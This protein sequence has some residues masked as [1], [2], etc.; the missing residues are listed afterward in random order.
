MSVPGRARL[1]GLARRWCAILRGWFQVSWAAFGVEWLAGSQSWSRPVR[2]GV[3]R[4]NSARPVL[5]IS[6]QRAEVGLLWF[7][8]R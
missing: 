7:V 8:A 6:C 2:F 1:F 4:R 3:E 5:K